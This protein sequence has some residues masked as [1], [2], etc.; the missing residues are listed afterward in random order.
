MGDNSEEREGAASG[1]ILKLHHPQL[2]WGG[3][4]TN[5]LVK[6]RALGRLQCLSGPVSACAAYLV[7]G[8]G[9]EAGRKMLNASAFTT[10]EKLGSFPETVRDCRVRGKNGPKALQDSVT[11][12]PEVGG[13]KRVTH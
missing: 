12:K 8:Q 9:G 2:R 7:A 11:Q 3:Q 6:L 10:S 5:C 4:S 13:S 1:G